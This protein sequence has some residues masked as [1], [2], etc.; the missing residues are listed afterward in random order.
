[1]KCGDDTNIPAIIMVTVVMMTR[2]I[3]MKVTPA[4][5]IIRHLT[6][7]ITTMMRR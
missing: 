2:T 3:M 7:T 5:R 6:K 4:T 1:M